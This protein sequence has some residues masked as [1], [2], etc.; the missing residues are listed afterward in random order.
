MRAEDSQIQDNPK[1]EKRKSRKSSSTSHSRLSK[2]NQNIN[3]RI[4]QKD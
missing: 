3:N 4:E 1:P 2:V